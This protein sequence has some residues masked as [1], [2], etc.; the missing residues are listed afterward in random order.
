[1]IRSAR[2]AI[3]RVI[4]NTPRIRIRHDVRLHRNRVPVLLRLRESRAED[5][6]NAICRVSG[7]VAAMVLAAGIQNQVSHADASENSE[8]ERRGRYVLYEEL[9]RGGARSPIHFCG[10]NP[11]TDAAE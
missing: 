8:P 10:I 3:A 5:S 11:F 9:G 4:Q 7:M 6:S 2:L 1:M